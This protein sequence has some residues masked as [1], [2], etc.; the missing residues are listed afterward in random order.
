MPGLYIER[1]RPVPSKTPE[2]SAGTVFTAKASRIVRAFLYGYP[3]KDWTR[4]ELTRVTQLSAGYVSTLV[5]RLIEQQYVTDR[6][7]L[8]YL[9]DPEQLLDDWRAH[10]RFDRH[11]RTYYAMNARTYDEGIEKLHQA[12]HTSGVEFAWTGW[13]GAYLRAPYA[14]PET[15]MAYVSKP[16]TDSDTVFQVD[17]SGN[18]VLLAAHDDGVFQ[19]VTQSTR[20]NIVS[21]AQ[22]YLDLSRMPGRAFEQADALR[23]MH[24]DFARMTG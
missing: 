19:F 9:D 23:Q 14:I 7:E 21:D 5:K 6:F 12:L 1:F 10:Y 13:T 3:Q 24:L 17:K 18:V 15:Y 8:L 22:L 2:P 4:A 20:G 11:K 16:L